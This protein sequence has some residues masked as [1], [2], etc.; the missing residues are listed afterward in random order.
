MD[1]E[2][3]HFNHALVT[4]DVATLC[5][6]FVFTYWAAPLMAR[7]A[8]AQYP[9]DLAPLREYLWLLVII[10]PSWT[11][12]LSVNRRQFNLLEA[13]PAGMGWHVLET[14]ILG[15]ALVTLFLYITKNPISRILIISEGTFS[16]CFLLLQRI[17][18]L[19]VVGIRR[20]R[21]WGRRGVLVIG[22]DDHAVAAIKSIRNDPLGR[23][24]VF[25][26]LARSANNRSPEQ[27][28]LLGSISDYRRLIW[29]TPIEEV[30]IGSD[31]ATEG[32]AAEIV[33]Y[34]DLVGI[35]ARMIP[36]YGIDPRLWPRMRLNS[37]F[38]MPAIEICSESPVAGK[39]VIK[40]LNDLVISGILLIL[41][42]P[43]FVL[44]AIAIKLSS[45]GPIFYRWRVLG[46]GGPPIHR[47]QVSFDGGRR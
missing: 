2:Q 7:Y 14:G 11:L 5:S 47:V 13:S 32:V 35:T 42:S 10:V 28:P 30:L 24:E 9:F 39:L 29:Q 27:I 40:R 20:R 33:H 46:R 18:I 44:I 43:V 34:C 37:F 3:S 12:L 26:V 16:A 38:G 21:G 23:M 41:L 15:T 6:A 19:W 4:A 22:T 17:A 45:P 25:G 8:L 31:V 1:R 36:N